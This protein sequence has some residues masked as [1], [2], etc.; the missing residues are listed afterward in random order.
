M[1]AYV[2]LLRAINVGGTGKIAMSDLKAL[3][4]AARFANVRTYIQSGNVV[5]ASRLSEAKARAALAKALHAHFG[6]PMGVL[7]RTA[8]EM[9]GVLKRNPFNTAPGNRVYV[10]FLPEAPAKTALAGIADP[11]FTGPDGEELNLSGRELF[12]H[13]PNGLGAS[14]LKLPKLVAAGTARNMNT[15][16]KLAQMAAED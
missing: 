7:I 10:H 1:T 5:F 11:G 4:E 16:A 3:C 9:A 15:V 12:V 14:K 6:K 8:D 13:Y 2:A